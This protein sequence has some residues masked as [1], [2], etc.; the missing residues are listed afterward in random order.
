MAINKVVIN[1]EVKLDL[2]QDSVTPESLLAG[3]TAHDAAG[4]PIT[5]LV[6]LSA[7]QD[8]IKAKGILVGDGA[9]GVSA[10]ETVSGDEVDVTTLPEVTEDDNGKFLRVVN[11][12]WTAV[13]IPDANGVNF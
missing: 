9:G 2:T 8:L 10:A 3:V 13:T 11:S 5:G 6:D 7:K 4:N 12:V 1:D